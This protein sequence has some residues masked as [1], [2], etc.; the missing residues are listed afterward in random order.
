MAKEREILQYFKLIFDETPFGVSVQDKGYNVIFSNPK[1]K[2]LFGGAE[3]EKDILKNGVPT[4]RIRKKNNKYFEVTAY[5]LE[6]KD[7][8]Y[9][10]K[11]VSD[12]TERE[13]YK[14][15]LEKAFKLEQLITDILCHD[16]LNPSGIIRNYIELLMEKDLP[17]ESRDYISIIKQ[18]NERL[19]KTIEDAANLA[20]LKNQRL[21]FEQMDLN[22]ILEKSIKDNNTFAE[23]KNIDIF[24]RETNHLWKQIL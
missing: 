7:E 14:T 8:T 1:Y 4:K 19:I 16:L 5:P 12:V 21:T 10:M 15:S 23:Q 17:K 9:I 13:E 20:K 22:E 11:F 3:D 24:L 18:N 2:E 6:F